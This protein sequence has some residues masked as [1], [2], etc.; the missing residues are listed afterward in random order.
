MKHLSGYAG[1]LQADAYGGYNALYEPG[2]SPGPIL[3][4]LCWVHARRPF[5]VLADIEASARR[6][7][8]G[9]TP[10]VISPLALEAVR[11]IDALFEIE[12]G[13]NGRTAEERKAERQ[14]LSAPLVAELELWMREQRAKA[15]ARKR[16]RQGDG[17]HTQAMVGLHPLPR[18]RTHLLIEQCRRTRAPRYRSRKAVLDVLWL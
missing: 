3:A 11:R 10:A 4:A 14:K 8:H 6:K 18:R 2:R 7:A 13:I 5:F 1:I 12:Q 15:R 17:L 9:K 16:C